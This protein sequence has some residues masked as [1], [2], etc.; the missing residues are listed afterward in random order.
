MR[1]TCAT[2]LPP[3]AFARILSENSETRWTE[4]WQTC[5]GEWTLCSV[6]WMGF[7]LSIVK[8]MVL[9]TYFTKLT[10]KIQLVLSQQILVFFTLF[11]KKICIQFEDIVDVFSLAD[12]KHMQF[13]SIFALKTRSTV[14]S[15]QNMWQE[16][17]VLWNTRIRCDYILR[18]HSANFECV[19]TMLKCNEKTIKSKNDLKFKASVVLH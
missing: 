16:L 8:C 9:M 6:S 2:R 15:H 18:L 3:D 19:Y 5:S 11:F 12:S 17:K 13:C 10:L 4:Y 14:F 7:A 1:C